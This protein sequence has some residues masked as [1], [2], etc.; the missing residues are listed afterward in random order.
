MCRCIGAQL[1]GSKEG[2]S[3]S[4]WLPAVSSSAATSHIALGKLSPDHGTLSS[5]GLCRLLGRWGHA[6]AHSTPSN[7]GG[8]NGSGLRLLLGSKTAAMAPMVGPPP[9]CV[10]PNNG[11]LPLWQV[12]T[13]SQSP[14]A[15]AHYTLAPVGCLHAVSPSTVLRS[16]LQSL[17]HS[18]QPWPMPTDKQTSVSAWIV[19]VDNNPLCRSFWSLPLTHLLC[20]PLRVWSLPSVSTSKR[21]SQYVETVLLQSSLPEAQVPSQFLSFFFCPTQLCGKFLVLLDV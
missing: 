11:P 4:T 18:T 20:S 15:V 10:P 14:S 1:P 8:S 7:G 19:L 2:R 3:S 5:S 9:P 17:N 16:E 12:Q 13:A 21:T 6:P